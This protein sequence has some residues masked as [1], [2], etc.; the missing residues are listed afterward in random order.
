M[1]IA[2]PVY[3]HFNTFSVI[4]L[5]GKYF[6]K[7]TVQA[8]GLCTK[9]N[10]IGDICGNYFLPPTLISKAVKRSKNAMEIFL[11]RTPPP[12]KNNF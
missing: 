2:K 10:F 4:A 8:M 6:S 9:N 12:Q 5:F 1:F 11:F 3:F 7:A